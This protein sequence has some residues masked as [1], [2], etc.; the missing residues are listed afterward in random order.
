M[1]AGRIAADYNSSWVIT[2]QTVTLIMECNLAFL[3][4]TE[5]EV[6]GIL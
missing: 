6:G 4:P 1:A 5:L 2:F 3:G